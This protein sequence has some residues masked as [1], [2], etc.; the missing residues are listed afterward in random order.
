L[1]PTLTDEIE[2]QEFTVDGD[3]VTNST[4]DGVDRKWLGTVIGFENVEAFLEE[5]WMYI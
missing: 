1:H 5:L 3:D 4:G 2:I